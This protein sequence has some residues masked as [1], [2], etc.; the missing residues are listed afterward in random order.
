MLIHNSRHIRYLMQEADMRTFVSLCT[1]VPNLIQ[2]NESF[3]LHER[4]PFMN[5]YL[6]AVLD[7]N[8]A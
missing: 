2:D 5:H 7:I 6:K 3:L 4:L 1:K 8:Q